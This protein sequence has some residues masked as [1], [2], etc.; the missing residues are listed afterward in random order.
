[1]SGELTE[2]NHVIAS[3]GE[4]LEVLVRDI[5]EDVAGD[6]EGYG[7]EIAERLRDNL[8]LLARGTEEE[9]REARQNLRHLRGQA[10]VI[11]AKRSL[12]INRR[13]AAALDHALEV[14]LPFAAQALLTMAKR[15]PM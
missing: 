14:V 13:L 2:L 1:M 10:V 11:A 7:R 6:I 12:A 5:L 9:Q 8:T 3:L 15:L 4:S